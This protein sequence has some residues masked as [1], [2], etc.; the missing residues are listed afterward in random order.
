MGVVK[1]QEPLLIEEGETK[2][3]GLNERQW[4]AVCFT[5]EMTRNVKVRD[6]TFEK[7][8]GLFS[9]REV[10]E[11]TAIVSLSPYSISGLSVF[12]SGVG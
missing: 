11:L 8:R 4:A 6:E 1:R 2:K 9:E 12:V 7:V 10:V 3:G 5:D